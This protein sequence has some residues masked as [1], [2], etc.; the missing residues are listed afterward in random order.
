MNVK[1]IITKMSKL[2]INF[3]GL[4]IEKSLKNAGL[5]DEI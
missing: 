1:V 3:G 5:I 4:H 2:S